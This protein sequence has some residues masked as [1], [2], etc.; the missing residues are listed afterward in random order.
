MT[1]R[2]TW[3]LCRPRVGRRRLL[4]PI[5]LARLEHRALGPGLVHE[6]GCW[7]CAQEKILRLAIELDQRAAR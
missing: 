7:S 2:R 6:T 4:N 3:G 1:S 5:E